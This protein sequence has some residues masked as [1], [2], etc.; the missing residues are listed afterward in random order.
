MTRT[1]TPSTAAAVADLT[2]PGGALDLGADAARL[3]TRMLR[4]LAQGAPLT[5]DRV[6]AAVAELGIDTDVAEQTLRAWTERD[7]DGVIR[8][9]ASPTTQPRTR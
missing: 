1:T 4:L 6:D 2:K 5:R 9:S 7:A 8:G 3:I